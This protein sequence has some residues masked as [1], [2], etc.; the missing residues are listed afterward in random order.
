MKIKQLDHFA[1]V[2]RPIVEKILP[3][4][5]GSPLLFDV[6]FNMTETNKKKLFDMI[7]PNGES[8]NIV[9]LRA[10]LAHERQD[11]YQWL[12]GV[13]VPSLLGADFCASVNIFVADGAWN[14][15]Q[16]LQSVRN[17][18]NELLYPNAKYRTCLRHLE[19]NLE[20]NCPGQ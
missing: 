7:I 19:S 9:V 2:Y 8:K 10:W 12:F 4:F 11:A 1:F 17:K 6:T 14:P 3:F 18:Q 16:V 15:P 13:A 20:K 5:I